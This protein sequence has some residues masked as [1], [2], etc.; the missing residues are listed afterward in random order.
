MAMPDA[1]SPAFARRIVDTA[2]DLAEA[3]AWED[4]RLHQVAAAMGVGLDDIR[5]HFR[6]KD[7]LIDAW[8]QRAD[9]AVLALADSGTMQALSPRERLFQLIM[10]WL[11]ALE[12]HRRVSRQMILSKLEPGHLH[13]QIPAL[14]GISR[15]VQW[16][17]EGA[18][19]ADSGIRRALLETA[20][21]ALYLAA[22][23]AWMREDAPG[24][25]DTRR[26]LGDLLARSEAIMNLCPRMA[27]DGQGADATGT[28]TPP[29][30]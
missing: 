11:D 8:F 24:S 21:T 4:V 12:E 25:P 2:V 1:I 16:I 10:A 9:D 18:L 27:R 17:R 3:S 22:F 6:E 5:S 29:P 19:L 15:T 26:L 20:V 14:M 30:S 7:A 23:A 28:A 13:I